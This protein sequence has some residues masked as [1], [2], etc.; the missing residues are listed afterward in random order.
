MRIILV[1]V[2]VTALV[3]I[4]AECVVLVLEQRTPLVVPREPQ[5]KSTSG[6]TL[7]YILLLMWAPNCQGKIQTRASCQTT[8]V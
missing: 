1:I 6:R 4:T 5:G 7:S 3:A 2:V 8:T